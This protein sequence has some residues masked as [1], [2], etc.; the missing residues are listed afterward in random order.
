M[1]ISIKRRFVRAYTLALNKKTSTIS[2]IIKA[3]QSIKVVPLVLPYN[4][5]M[6]SVME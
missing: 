1:R 5:V 6:W 3:L 4:T 2:T